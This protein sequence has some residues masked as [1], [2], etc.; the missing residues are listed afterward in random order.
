MEDHLSFRWNWIRVV[1]VYGLTVLAFASL[2]LIPSLK[3]LN[4]HKLGRLPA[5]L[6]WV[7]VLPMGF[8][9][10]YVSETIPRILF[11]AIEI[12]I[13]HHL[14]F[15]PGVDCLIWQAYSP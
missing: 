10:G 6:R 11:A 14:T 3:L 2:I 12:A 1:V 13:N 15:R 9:V 7:L 5:W 8:L 4:S